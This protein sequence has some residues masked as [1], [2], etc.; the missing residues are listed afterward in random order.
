[1]HKRYLKFYFLFLV[2]LAFPAGHSILFLYRIG[3]LDNPA[4][5]VE[6]QNKHPYCIYG[7]ALFDNPLSIKMAMYKEKRPEVITLGSSRMLQFRESFFRSRFYNMGY[8]I[9][10][11]SSAGQVVDLILKN[12]APKVVIMNVDF[13]WFHPEYRKPGSV[14]E[15]KIENERQLELNYGLLPL[16]WLL[17]KKISTYDF[18]IMPFSLQ[19]PECGIGTK[20]YERN[21]GY[22]PDGSYY[23]TDVLTGSPYTEKTG[24]RGDYQFKDIKDRISKGERSFNY[25]SEPDKE[26]VSDF[27]KIIAK[28]KSQGSKVVLIYPPIAP[29]TLELMKGHNYSYIPKLKAELKQNGINIYDYSD[30]GSYSSNC[31]FIDGFHGGDLLYARVLLDLAKHEKAIAGMIDKDYLEKVT[32]EYKNLAMIP[33]PN[34]T[35]KPENDFLGIGCQ[36]SNRQP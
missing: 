17:N 10:S 8:I 30:V 7:S 26:H 16:K 34:I 18:F 4:Q 27:L 36:K 24:V 1:M 5:V 25:G 15:V 14:D 29:E 9:S 33:N 12:Q 32:T 6:T 23:Y 13:W 31:E 35:T 28:L 19:K 22:A 11:I 21:A 2:I 20:G 3:E